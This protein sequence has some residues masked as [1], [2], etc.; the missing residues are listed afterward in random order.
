MDE[1]N[2][3]GLSEHFS[4][5]ADSLEKSILRKKWPINV[6]GVMGKHATRRT[7]GIGVLEKALNRKRQAIS[8]LYGEPT[9]KQ[10]KLETKHRTTFKTETEQSSK[11]SKAE[12]NQSPKKT[13]KAEANQSPTT[14]DVPDSWK[15]CVKIRKLPDKLVQLLQKSHEPVEPK[16]PSKPVSLLKHGHRAKGVKV[17]QQAQHHP[18]TRVNRTSHPTP[19]ASKLLVSYISSFLCTYCI[20]GTIQV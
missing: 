11:S 5:D 1:G 4:L 19:T 15:P 14:F 2:Q 7:E 3:P 10:R 18:Q 6:T 8:G 12:R 17:A 9:R 16:Q 20:T 13:R